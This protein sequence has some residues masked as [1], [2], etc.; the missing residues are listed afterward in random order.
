MSDSEEE[1]TT[2]EPTSRLRTTR[3]VT[4]AFKLSGRNYPLWSRLMKV[5]IGSRRGFSHITDEPPEPDSKG[6]HEWEETVLVVFSWIVDNIETDILADFAHHQTS[7]ALWDNLQITFESKADPYLIYDL[8]DKVISIRQ[9]DMDLETYYRRIHGLWVSVDETQKSPVTCCDKGVR[10]FRQFSSEKRLIKFLTGLNGEFDGIR[11]DILKLEPY[12]SVEEAYVYV[13]RE[14]ARRKIM[15]PASSSLTGDPSSARS[16]DASSGEIGYGFGAQKDRPNNRNGPR[17]PPAGGAS[18]QTRTKPDKSKLWCSHCGKNKHTRENC[19][20]RV[21]YP[22]WWDERQRARAQAK[23]AAANI[24][25]T[26]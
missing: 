12:P 13:K 18:H 19:F 23:F 2:T 24:A 16:A 6:Y 4:V 20:L 1:K 22:E 10:Q 9:G 7:K 14:A 11:R 17:P 21:G 15:P 26:G 8:E 5:A 3:N 25:E